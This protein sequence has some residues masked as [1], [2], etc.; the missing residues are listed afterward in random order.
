MLDNVQL[1]KQLTPHLQAVTR[2]VI[3]NIMLDIRLRTAGQL[4]WRKR[5]G[6]ITIMI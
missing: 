3:L 2:V 1:T 6:E 4:K 5:I